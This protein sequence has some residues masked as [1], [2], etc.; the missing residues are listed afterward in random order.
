MDKVLFTGQAYRPHLNF[1]KG[2]MAAYGEGSLFHAGKQYAFGGAY[3]TRTVTLDDTARTAVTA[4]ANDHDA[5][6]FICLLGGLGIL[7]GRY[8]DT[9]HVTVHTPL[10][11]SGA[12]KDIFTDKVPLLLNADGGLTL[13]D[14]LNTTRETVK[15]CYKYQNVPPELL[16][17]AFPSNVF[18]SYEGMHASLMPAGTAYDLLILFK[19]ELAVWTITLHYR[20]GLYDE[21]LIAQ[22]PL[23]LGHVL[24]QYAQPD[25]P[26][27]EIALLPLSV[28]RLLTAENT[29]ALPPCNKGLVQLIEEQAAAL[30]HK[31]ALV[32]GDHCLTYGELN[33]QVNRLSGYLQHSSGLRIGDRVGILLA[34]REE[35]VIAI[36]AVMKAGAVYVP[37]DP[38]YPASRISF[39]MEDAGLS[40]MICN[41]EYLSQCGQSL[42][43]VLALDHCRNELA[44]Y[45]KEN[46]PQISRPQLPAY[47]IYTSGSTGRPK[48]VVVTH[49]SVLNLLRALQEV[50]PL[51]ARSV[52][53]FT[54]S[55]AFD[56]A[57]KNIFLPLISGAT[58]CLGRELRDIDGLLTDMERY[59]VTAMHATPA[60]WNEVVSDLSARPRRIY[61]ECISAGG[62]RL[63]S[64]LANKLFTTFQKTIYNLYGP[65][66]GC[67]N[68]TWY[69][70]S[71]LCSEDPP[72]GRP[73]P[74]YRI[75]IT[76]HYGHLLPAGVNGE[77]CIA[78]E[79]VA[80]GY[81]N[82]Q[83]LSKEKF[84][85]SPFAE[86]ERLYRTGDT[87]RWLPGGA[88]AFGGRN[89][90]QV[91]LNG[92]RIE[93]GEIEN[94]LRSHDG[95]HDALVI[96]DGSMERLLA[97]YTG[98]AALSEQ[99]LRSFLTNSLPVYMVPHRLVHLGSFPL[100]PSGKVDHKRLL[101]VAVAQVTDYIPPAN[102]M[103]EILQG[104]WTSLLGLER[105]SVDADF[106]HSGGNSLKAVKLAYDIEH[107]LGVSIGIRDL[108][109][110]PDIRQQ[111]TAITRMGYAQERLPSISIPLVEKKEY[112]D[113]SYGQQRQWILDQQEKEQRIY[114]MSGVLRLKGALDA[115]AV[116]KA[117]AML[118]DR[119]ESLRTVFVSIDGDLKQQVLPEGA[120]YSFRTVRLHGEDDPAAKAAAMIRKADMEIFDL[121][122]GPLFKVSLFDLGNNDYRLYLSFDHIIADG[123][124]M[125]V[126]IR[127]FIVLYN[128]VTSQSASLP[129]LPVQ[130]KDV[131]AFQNRKA[132]DP[133]LQ[134]YW[135][136]YLAEGADELL[137]PASR[138]RPATKTNLG[139]S[140]NRVLN[141]A[142]VNNLC[143]ERGVTAFMFFM[144]ALMTWLYRV[145]GQERL[146]VGTGVAG[147]T[148]PDLEQQVGLLANILP[149]RASLNGKQPFAALLSDMKKNA[150]QCF[151]KQEYP[152]LKLL[153][154]LNIKWQKNRSPLFDVMLTVQRDYL[155]DLQLEGVRIEEEEW[156]TDSCLFDLYFNIIE[157][158]RS[159]KIVLNYDS[160]LFSSQE[161]IRML[162]SFCNLLAMLTESP[163]IPLDAYPLGI[164]ASTG[165]NC[166]VAVVD[167]YGRPLTTGIA[168]T[169]VVREDE[170]P[171]ADA[172]RVFIDGTAFVCTYDKGR[173]IAADRLEMLDLEPGGYYLH[174][175]YYP[176]VVLEEDIAAAYMADDCKI[177][178]QLLNGARYI[179][180]HI[181]GITVA[182][183]SM[184]REQIIVNPL[185]RFPLNPN[186]EI[187]IQAL[188]AIP[189][190]P[191]QHLLEKEI[192][193]MADVKH[194][195]IINRYAYQAAPVLYLGDVPGI[196]KMESVTA[197]ATAT[198]IRSNVTEH[199][200]APAQPAWSNGGDLDVPG[201]TLC[202]ALLRTGQQHPHKGIH[203]IQDHAAN[204]AFL[205]Y[206]TLLAEALRMAAGLQAGKIATGRP[207]LLQVQDTRYLFP[208]FWACVLSGLRPVIV[209][210]PP[211]YDEHNS[212]LD[213]LFH[214]WELLEHPYIISDAPSQISSIRQ[215]FPA[216]AAMQAL[217]VSQL[218][219]Y[220]GE[221]RVYEAAP[222]EVVFYQL[223]SGSTGAPKCIAIT[224]EGVV[225]HIEGTRLNNGLQESD[226]TLNWMPFDHVGAILT[227]HLKDTYMGLNQVQLATSMVLEEPL[228]WL[229]C[230]EKYRVTHTW[231][232]N[233]GYRLVADALQKAGHRKWDLSS[234]KYFMNGGEQVNLHVISDF[235]GRTQLFGV[236]PE[237]I[238][239]AFGM[240]EVCTAFI[241]NNEFAKGKSVHYIRKNSL[242]GILE[243]ADAEGMDTATFIEL[244]P[245]MPGVEIR[246]TDN[247]NKV[248]PERKIGRFQIRGKSVTPGYFGNGQANRD[249]FVGDGW[250]NSG[251][252]GF[253]E[254][255]RL[256]LTGRE[257]EMIVVRGSNFYCSEIEDFTGQLPGVLATY[258]A[259]CPVRNRLNEMEEFVLFYV[260]SGGEDVNADAFVL[261]TGIQAA[262]AARFGISPY[263]VL[264]LSK[265]AFPKTTSGKI[266]RAQ[267]QAAFE[268]GRFNAL[269]REM[270]LR[271]RH[272]QT[273]LPAWFFGRRWYR[274]QVRPSIRK[275]E[276]MDVLL[277]TADG[278]LVNAWE[279]QYP[280]S[281]CI[282]VKPGTEYRE[283]GPGAFVLHPYTSAHYHQL[284]ETL[285]SRG[286]TV[287]QVVHGW[288]FT[289]FEQI[290][291]EGM[292][293]AA[294][295]Y[296]MGL[297]YT[298]Q[299]LPSV[300][301]EQLNLH[302][303][304]S[305]ARYIKEND[306][307]MPAKSLL[308]ALIMSAGQEQNWLK[309]SCL[310]LPFEDHALLP[311][312]LMQE[313]NNRPVDK[314]KAYRSG[315]RMVCGLAQLEWPLQQEGRPLYIK[316]GGMYLVAGGLGKIGASLC[317]YLLE[318]YGITLLIIGRTA[319]KDLLSPGM[320]RKA[321]ALH[322]LRKLSEQVEYAA[323]TVTDKE[324]LSAFI[325]SMESRYNKQLDGII[326]LSG[327]EGDLETHFRN[328][329]RH[330]LM[331]LREDAVHAAFGAKVLGTTVLA[332]LVMERPYATLINFSTALTHSGGASA[333]LYTAISS[334][335]DGMAFLDPQI[336]TLNWSNWVADEQAG[337]ARLTAEKGFMPISVQEGVRS[338]AVALQAGLPQV[339]IGLDAEN[340]AVR[341]SCYECSMNEKQLLFYYV[342]GDHAER[343]TLHQK[344][345]TLC[346]EAGLYNR[347]GIKTALLEKDS[348][349]LDAAGKVLRKLLYDTRDVDDAAGAAV[350]QT[351][352]EQKLYHIWQDVLDN[353]KI[354]T[355]VS[356]FALGGDS[357]KAIQLISR[358]NREFDTRLDLKHLFEHASIQQLAAVLEAPMG[359]ASII[360][361]IPGQEDYEVS[362]AQRRL[363]LSWQKNKKDTAYNISCAYTLTGPLDVNIL[364]KAFA[365][366]I[367]RHEIMRTGIVSVKG[368]P[369][370]KIRPLQQPGFRLVLTDLQELPDQQQI[371]A[372]LA[373]AA[374][375]HCFDLEHDMLFNIQL[376]R[377]SPLVHVLLFT[378]HHIISDGWSM[379][380]L[381]REV[382]HCYEA[383][384]AGTLPEL[385]ALPIQY[386]EYA[387]WQHEMI[388]SG[389]MDQQRTYWMKKLGKG[390]PV[391][392][393]PTDH[394]RPAVRSLYGASVHSLLPAEVLERLKFLSTRY[395]VSLFMVMLALTDIL[396]HRYTGQE[397]FVLKTPVAGR[398]HPELEDQVGCYINTLVLHASVLE[399]DT[400]ESLL[401]R[402]KQTAMEA[403]EQQEYPVDMLIEDLQLQWAPNR[404][405]FSDVVVLFL[406]ANA[407]L[408]GDD[409]DRMGNIQVTAYDTGNRINQFDLRL[410]FA[411]GTDSMDLKIDY[412]VDLYRSDTIERMAARLLQ[413]AA[414]LSEDPG[415]PVMQVELDN[416]PRILSPFPEQELQRTFSSFGF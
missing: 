141:A 175:K 150:L 398:N 35:L 340:D 114:N 89:D 11:V 284:A 64:V 32:W 164:A 200:T 31:I 54:T 231:S 109:S 34:N 166:P 165:A 214:A 210:I 24:S 249:A 92:Y 242:G 60:L 6:I 286:V 179:V 73:L 80:A 241:Y 279:Q 10:N 43:P 319:E 176:A 61:L 190:V 324:Q 300:R 233:F 33:E 106:F 172:E 312:I 347:S 384:S 155:A 301:K 396:V 255:G 360:R 403:F 357:L 45:S 63:S 238:Q 182:D 4:L 287:G 217:E 406:N 415:K 306:R 124:S 226:V 224:H 169:V 329:D 53:I 9:A 145:T 197:S 291:M 373:E 235:L 311:E 157:Q 412:N 116:E 98:D 15:A 171:A 18:V 195:A 334:F 358:I 142:P 325:G 127:D 154:D 208:V 351:V 37:L 16:D 407:R 361:P 353:G 153:E 229:E 304:T 209:A 270:D 337:L 271:V 120:A 225:A 47:I 82:M 207:V 93:P 258:V 48:G 26:V 196:L 149:L 144:S 364:E 391:L 39:I 350:P 136:S 310:D 27:R 332:A 189:L 206:S 267:L 139:K 389:Q 125:Q 121:E 112:Y 202:Q 87:G 104:I 137:L 30:P 65:T 76:D 246:I 288:Y 101:Q 67:V 38:L 177:L 274:K 111:A 247:E 278:S 331:N 390:V 400:F 19:R 285:A 374:A 338:L 345:H 290:P 404:A 66:E 79:G 377:T 289:P 393:F 318:Y 372:G 222:A 180:A 216:A 261:M 42:V 40:L 308:P 84:L 413:L 339:Y 71:S 174:G 188:S 293:A 254:N 91:K 365:F 266:Q 315:Q 205:S 416:G 230:I 273:T 56:A 198:V 349:P 369:R 107:K 100:L 133:S 59:R 105:V 103:E 376:L 85:N 163:L 218:L 158:E 354:S 122:K 277:F 344:I 367:E 215:V 29:Q 251:D 328:I 348:L 62:D 414:V 387:A 363:W 20:A 167:A 257:K 135:R 380:I 313:V 75:Y 3:R 239:P 302:L 305:Y 126:L 221:G 193:S 317:T 151:E 181:D 115:P 262:V 379:N 253:I 294:V 119:H 265:E 99:L 402:V 411:E 264:P 131:A 401:L 1:W 395:E 410:V 132:A 191:E 160:I 280:G 263:Y 186:G 250:F 12:P 21:Q 192:E 25:L 408:N 13:K 223:S 130:Y 397:N 320:E 381:A 70:I 240:A 58:L 232:P 148:H 244:G 326:Q 268:E 307:I 314:E 321:E 386:K 213:K 102:E 383:F 97:F 322:Q 156:E 95:I 219:Q 118:V 68:A 128:N 2:H 168:G 36:L 283:E 78:G 342:P 123:A 14:Y 129:P 50:L 370:Q 298:L 333:S 248:L 199:G 194:C 309:S 81:L 161:A 41:S 243:K 184:F 388:H 356:F 69:P 341:N 173:W 51:H 378:T 220:N 269:I 234:I 28:Q 57:V 183:N 382:M 343:E 260:P 236:R 117:C 72:I 316:Q 346:L 299:L 187:D 335:Q 405:P 276:G 110:M 8:M 22:L 77:I 385:P 44:V 86:G 394:E 211:A 237:H 108:F 147:R 355:K 336:R 46:P 55:P 17:G 201:Y 281:R 259:A 327:E 143:R 227:Y 296:F 368:V 49:H 375:E 162:E 204:A 256:T 399:E 140:I 7:L 212:V 371:I 362:H 96:T 392:D 366:F 5:A 275:N 252:L 94:Q 159:F 83:A 203:F 295:H 185:M 134:Q 352:T 170:M 330:L 297:L 245:P 228:L 272:P 90:A 138:P 303:V 88:I 178:N 359:K 74:G 146:T 113:T 282:Q 292:A 323:V 409:L 23:H 152:F 52:Y